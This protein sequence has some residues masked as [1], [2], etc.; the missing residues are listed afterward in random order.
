M[1]VEGIWKGCEL[2]SYKWEQQGYLAIRSKHR[3][4]DILPELWDVFYEGSLSIKSS[5]GDLVVR[6]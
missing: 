5:T 4:L 2:P 6:N 3:K 1:S